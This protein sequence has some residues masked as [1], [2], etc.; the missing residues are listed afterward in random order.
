M[1]FWGI[2]ANLFI[3]A[4][5][6]VY[7]QKKYKKQKRAQEAAADKQ[8]GQKFSISGEAAALPVVYGK[9][10]IGG[11]KTGHAVS[12]TF[13]AA[14]LN[15]DTQYEKNFT[16]GTQS[17]AK[18]EFL[19]VQTALCH[20]GIEGVQHIKVDDIDYRG[21]TKE[22]KEDN[23][24]FAHRFHIHNS[25]GTA[26]SG[27]SVN[28]FASTNTFTDTT[29]VT[30]FFKLN[31]VNP[32]YNGSPDVQYIIKGRKIRKISYDGTTHTLNSGYEYSNNPAYALL[33]YLLSTKFGR[34][35]TTSQV[36]LP[37]F[38]NA[39]SISDTVV[40]TGATIGGSVNGV[41]PIFS[42][43]SQA[44]FP[45]ANVTP[46][47]ATFLYYAENTTTLYSMT[48]SSGTPTYTVTTAPATDSIRLYECNITLDTQQTIRDNIERLLA[49][50]GMADFVWTPE[51]KYKLILDH[52]ADAAATLALVNSNHYF[53]DDSIVRDDVSLIWPSAQDRFTQVTV[54]FDNEA[55]NFKPDSVTWPPTSNQVGDPYYVY[56]RED[57]NNPL[58]TSLTPDGVTNKY[59]ALAYAEQEVR[60]S[61]SL[62]TLDISL[63]RKAFTV[64]PGDLI[65]IKSDALGLE[66]ASGNGYTFRVEATEINEDFSVRVKCYFF[67]E[68]VLAW[69]V[70]DDVAYATIPDIDFSISAPT[71][72]AF[73]NGTNQLYGSAAGKLTWT[74]ADDIGVKDYIIEASID[75]GTTYE[76]LGTTAG[77]T[78]DVLGMKQGTYT[79]SVR[80]RSVANRL[81]NRI[82]ITGITL[83]LIASGQVTVIFADDASGTN[84]T[85]TYGSQDFA[86]YFSHTGA[87]PS[88]PIS[89]GITFVRF[90]GTDGTNG[91]AGDSVFPI[92]ATDASGSNPS[93]SPS[94]KSHVNFYT[95]ASTPSLPVSGLSYTPLGT[96]GERGA[97]WWRYVDTSN[98]IA[99]YGTGNQAAIISAF[100]TAT[101]YAGVNGDRFIIK[102]TD[103]TEAYIYNGSAWAAQADFIDGDLMV[104]GT[105]TSDKMSVTTLSAVVADMGTLTAGKLESADGKFKIDLTNKTILITV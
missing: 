35:L 18:R 80:S 92:Y 33:D 93:F 2:V 72:L 83:Q 69:N 40:L 42:Y 100:A 26:D 91:S 9:Q 88:L 25:G 3:G 82:Q 17:G 76:E 58:T 21:Y 23:A 6:A 5:S 52:P 34:G 39:A 103:A 65:N 98:A 47:Q 56:L 4:A 38:Y 51:G 8:R 24:E 27:A 89:S 19:A 48:Q 104:A 75:S 59:H 79:F 22:M 99:T 64:E 73:T 102:A 68:E 43:V 54:Q 74:A 55:E 7:Q 61:R 1:A 105:V 49:T 97:G 46:Q 67:D 95:A 45:S 20:S 87:L 101:T 90:S 96:A 16:N 85:L 63:T 53:T 10:I 31:R 44:A 11:I 50:M 77:L 28:G 66:D 32:Q 37:S 41:K 13:T 29:H 14:T 78:F 30:S 12:N 62:Y 71:N 86:A 81:S 60:K 36:D 70:A 84:Q 94:G 15:S 57:N